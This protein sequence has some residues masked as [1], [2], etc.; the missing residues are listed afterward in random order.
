MRR[1]HFIAIGIAALALTWPRLALADNLG[2]MKRIGVLDILDENDSATKARMNA[3]LERLRQLGWSDNVNV[4]I[5]VLHAGGRT[6]QLNKLARDLVEHSVDVLLTSGTPAVLAAKQASATI[7]IV[8]ATIGDPVGAGAVASLSRPGGNVTGLSL[9]S[10]D[11]SRKRLELLKE[12]LPSLKRVAIFWNPG[13]SSLALQLQ[14]TEE[15]ARLLGIEMQSIAAITADDFR[16]GIITARNNNANALL[17]MSDGNQVANR[18]Q[19]IEQATRSHLPV[20]GEY[21]QFA[22]AGALLSY[23]PNTV[24][25]WR[26]AADYVDKILKGAKPSDIPVEQPVRFELV[27]NLKTAKA[28][29]VEL[30][31]SI[32]LRADQVI[33]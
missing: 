30:P 23:G 3:F 32:L 27:I 16:A 7:P 10:T 1:R 9:Q 2:R 14:D 20:L 17:L 22:D 5:D 13:N 19:I 29:G 24:D 15:A 6:D 12:V 11:L 28:I 31:T 4:K 25:N 26:R 21:S 8:F 18:E 33:E